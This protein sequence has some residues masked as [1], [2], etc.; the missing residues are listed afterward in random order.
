MRM[1]TYLWGFEM[2]RIQQH[3]A[4]LVL[5]A[6]CLSAVVLLM[7]GCNTSPGSPTGIGTASV[8]SMGP[9][10]T[11]AQ[12]QTQSPTLTP[13]YKPASEKG[14]AENVPL[15]VMPEAAK[16]KSKEGLEAFARYWYE[17]VNYGYETGD[18]EPLRAISGPDCPVCGNFYTM[19]DDGF[20]G[21]D[22]IAGGEIVIQ[23][24][25]SNFVASEADRY[26]VLVQIVQN[27]STYFGPSGVLGQK[28]GFDTAAVQMIEATFAD[29]EWFADNVVTIQR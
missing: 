16:I 1:A 23:S 13:T 28:E 3:R 7:V 27:P 2:N 21:D 5:P 22:W 15:P 18:V 12:T 10:M 14:P 6:V 19:V 17:L 29:G 8:T 26:Q 20:R 25:H 9:S 4:G 24:V 11:P